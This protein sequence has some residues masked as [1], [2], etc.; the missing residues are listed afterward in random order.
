MYVNNWTVMQMT[1]DRNCRVYTFVMLIIWVGYIYNGW[2]WVMTFIIVFS[3]SEYESSSRHKTASKSIHMIIQENP[4]NVESGITQIASSANENKKQHGLWPQL[5]E[6]VS[7]V[8]WRY[9]DL[10]THHDMLSVLWSKSWMFYQQFL[11]NIPTFYVFT[12]FC[13]NTHVCWITPYH[14]ATLNHLL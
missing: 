14:L 3:A 8:L 2:Y 9:D 1:H 10:I 4:N 5:K 12:P 13:N 6:Y 11:R 7:A